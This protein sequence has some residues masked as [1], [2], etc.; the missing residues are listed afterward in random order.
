M[1]DITREEIWDNNFQKVEETNKKSRLKHFIAEHKIITVLLITLG[2]LMTANVIL[3][4]NFLKV[5]A[6]M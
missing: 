5:I 2:I 3:I 4:Y 6:N 1:I